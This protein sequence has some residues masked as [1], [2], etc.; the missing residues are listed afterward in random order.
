MNLI[1]ILV[2]YLAFAA[3]FVYVLI[4]GPH[5]YHRNGIVGRAHR[6]ITNA[7]SVVGKVV[8]RVLACGNKDKGDRMFSKFEDRVMNRRHPTLQIFYLG[9]MA[10]SFYIFFTYV[11]PRLPIEGGS[12][13]VMTVASALGI[14]V[15]VTACVKDPGTVMT[16]A[17]LA[18]APEW[19]R[20]REERL[21]KRYV[22]DGTLFDGGD[23]ST[24]EVKK[25]AR[26]KHCRICGHC[27]RRFDHHCAWLNQDVGEGNLVWFHAFLVWH[28][29]LS[30]T[31]A[32]LSSLVLLSW[33]EHEGLWD[34]QFMS[35]DGKRTNATG[36]VVA[37]Y[38][39]ANHPA[40]CALIV[41]ALIV[42]VMLFVFWLSHLASAWRSQT[43]NEKF[44]SQDYRDFLQFEFRRQLRER[45]GAAKPVDKQSPSDEAFERAAQDLETDKLTP[46]IVRREIQRVEQVYS[47]GSRWRNVLDML[48]VRQSAPAKLPNHGAPLVRPRRDATAVSADAGRKKRK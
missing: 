9:I 36:Y 47:L 33:I 35:A 29:L 2:A 39:V 19:K 18:S 48:N 12:R 32:G 7:P 3:V 37:M 43:S 24:C 4:M 15:Y 10:G 21:N 17:Q 11:Y 41:F 40:I 31:Y 28:V 45:N 20:K 42:G 23:C 1:T 27:V 30:W 14:A 44:K 26:S 5:P 16:K 13:E 38:T 25:P 8:C 6:M 34:A 22:P 46:E